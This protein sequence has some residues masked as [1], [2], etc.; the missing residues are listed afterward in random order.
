MTYTSKKV[1]PLQIHNK[2]IHMKKGKEKNSWIRHI[3][4][5]YD[6]P[7]E[8]EKQCIKEVEYLISTFDNLKEVPDEIVFWTHLPFEL[9]TKADIKKDDNGKYTYEMDN[10]ESTL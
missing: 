5:W 1:I 4:E 9:I 10:T 6:N 2:L 3:G 8:L 7:D